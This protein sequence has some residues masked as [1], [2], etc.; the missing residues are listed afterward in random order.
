[1]E[2]YFYYNIMRKTTIQFL[3]MFSDLKIARYDKDTLGI[4]KLINVPL[5]F[6]PKEKGYMWLK[7]K[8]KNLVVPQLALYV[9]S[10]DFGE[11]RSMN[12]NEYVTFNETI[13]GANRSI[14]DYMIPT[15]YNINYELSI[16]AIQMDD[17]FQCIEQILPFFNPI[18][19]IRLNIPEV[20][21]Q[22]TIKIS[23]EGASP[24]QPI[25]LDET[26]QRILKW[27]LTFVAHA[28][29]FKPIRLTKP[30]TKI[31]QDIYI[32]K[33]K[34]DARSTST[35]P[36]PSAAPPGGHMRYLTHGLGYDTD[37]SIIYN[38]DVFYGDDV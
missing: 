35:T 19:Y 20:D 27:D 28:L 2:D 36:V 15:P 13:S 12:K 9:M 30:I 29:L 26:S 8:S 24:D 31:I 34:F 21:T 3:N 10:I 25:E 37:G 1:M 16:Y 7:N 32:N 22:H 18:A 17:I 4:R 5:K 14:S 33:D 11:D 23:Y 6:A 38:Q